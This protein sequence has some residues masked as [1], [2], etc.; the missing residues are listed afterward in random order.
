VW[1]LRLGVGNMRVD[2]AKRFNWIVQEHYPTDCL[3]M[4]GREGLL[5]TAVWLLVEYRTDGNFPHSFPIRR[6]VR[7]RRK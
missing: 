3:P 7:T 5:V 2:F 6:V 1:G 4:Q